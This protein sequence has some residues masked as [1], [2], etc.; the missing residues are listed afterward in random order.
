MKNVKQE[1]WQEVYNLAARKTRYRM[2]FTAY[3][4]LYKQLERPIEI[5]VWE[6]PRNEIEKQLW[7]LLRESNNFFSRG[8]I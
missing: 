8:K 4:R 5:Q 1:V 7:V 6:R 2:D 3:Q